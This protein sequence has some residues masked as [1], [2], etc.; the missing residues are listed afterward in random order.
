MKSK[1]L[2][3]LCVAIVAPAG[4]PRVWTEAGKLLAIVQHKAQVKFWSMVLEPGAQRSS[5]VELVATAF[6]SKTGP[7]ESASNCHL[8]EG[9]R[10]VNRVVVA[11]ANRGSIRQESRGNASQRNARSSAFSD[12]LIAKALKTPRANGSSESFRHTRSI[13]ESDEPLLAERSLTPV[14]LDGLAVLPQPSW[15]DEKSFRFMLAPTAAPLTSTLNEK[16]SVLILKTIKK[17]LEDHK[18]ARPKGR[19]RMR[20]LEPGVRI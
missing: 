7:A 20:N 3:I 19:V 9:N 1:R 10:P 14:V 16:D 6:S 18:L 15:N 5:N 2:T 4:S 8:E 12:A 17:A 13:A 11:R